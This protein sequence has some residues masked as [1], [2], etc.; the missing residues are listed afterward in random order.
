MRRLRELAAAAAEFNVIALTHD[1]LEL[2]R[3]LGARASLP[4]AAGSAVRPPP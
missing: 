4:Q 1:V 3:G 2:F